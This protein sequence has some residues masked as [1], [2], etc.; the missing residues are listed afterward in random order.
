MIMKMFTVFDSKAEAYLPPFYLSTRGQAIR[1]FSDSAND[2]GHAFNKHPS[3][4]TL[5]MI[6]EFDD[7]DCGIELLQAKASLGLAL[8]FKTQDSDPVG[9]NSLHLSGAHPRQNQIVNKPIPEGN[10]DG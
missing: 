9:G 3:D 2:P 5:F 6:G 4:Y 7:Q 10:S 1:A 8:E